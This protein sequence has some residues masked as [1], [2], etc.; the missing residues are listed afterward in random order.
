MAHARMMAL[1]LSL[2]HGALADT[3]VTGGEYAAA[4]GPPVMA[5]PGD[6]ITLNGEG[7]FGPA[8]ATL[9]YQWTQRSGPAV[10]LDLPTSSRPAFTA[11]EPGT[12]VFE[13]VV[14]DGQ[15]AWSTPSRSRIAI[16]DRDSGQRLDGCTTA[17]GAGWLGVLALLA[18]RRVSA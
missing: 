2:S 4:A 10:D 6:R 1:A 16:I 15:D 17:P 9:V 14:G 5:Y 13:L 8:G 12:H 18:I 3:G 7:S 11:L